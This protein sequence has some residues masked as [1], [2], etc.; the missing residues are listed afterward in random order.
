MGGNAVLWLAFGVTFAAQAINSTADFTAL[1]AG[2]HS[3]SVWVRGVGNPSSCYINPGNFGMTVL[4]D[5]M[6]SR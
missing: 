2:S 6:P 3:I 1:P 4:V 5:E